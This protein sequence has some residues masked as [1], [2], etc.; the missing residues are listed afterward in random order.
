MENRRNKTVTC[1]DRFTLILYGLV[2]HNRINLSSG[3]LIILTMLL[4]LVISVNRLLHFF[5]KLGHCCGECH[6][7]YHHQPKPIPFTLL[8]DILMQ[9]SCKATTVT[10]K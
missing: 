8:P 10:I 9:K 4:V 6:R 7:I 5:Q 1:C 2:M 3:A